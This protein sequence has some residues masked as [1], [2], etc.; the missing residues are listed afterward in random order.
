METREER[1]A[2]RSARGAE[3]RGRILNAA[4]AALAEEGIDRFTTRRVA[5]RAGVSHGMVHYHFED[6]RDL[7]LALVV[8][9]RRDWVEPL[10]ELVDGPGTA[11]ARMRAVISWMAEPATAETMR[12]HMGLFSYALRDDVVRERLG[13]EFGRWRAPFVK[14][15]EELAA[16]LG[17]EGLDARSL[18]EAF[19][20]A[21]DAFVQQ[22]SLDPSLPTERFLTRL[23]ERLVGV[24]A[25][26]SKAQPR[27]PSSRR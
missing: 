27:R 12:V 26:G 3:T 19:G 20:S 15:F 21:A 7:I 2:T 5:D 17:I 13:A 22:Q 25:K 14:L 16:E 8:H 4:R 24:P 11:V 18:G 10:E 23:F 9:A 1:S 6:K